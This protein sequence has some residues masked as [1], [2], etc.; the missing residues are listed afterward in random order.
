MKKLISSIVATCFCLNVFAHTGTVSALEKHIDE[1]QYAL[2]VEWDQQDE[3][4]REAQTSILL[5][6]L[7]QTATDGALSTAEIEALL[8]KRL[9]GNQ[10]LE[11]LK[12]RL[13]LSPVQST[14]EMMSFI[15][16]HSQDFYQTGVSWN[17]STGFVVAGVLAGIAAFAALIIWASGPGAKCLR[18]EYQYYCL[19]RFGLSNQLLT[20]DCRDHRVCAEYKAYESRR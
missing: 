7:Q 18:Y 19:E 5:A 14:S 17:G 1:F 9:G 6:K 8:A 16:Q 3:G 13:S 12:L 20:Q 10:A 4:F 15:Q 11:A 2:T